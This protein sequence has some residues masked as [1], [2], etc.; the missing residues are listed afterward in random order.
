MEVEQNTEH[1]IPKPES[2]N[3]VL[4]P[5]SREPGRDRV[6]RWGMAVGLLVLSLAVIGAWRTQSK[7][8][9][10]QDSSQ[11]ATR[12]KIARYLRERFSLPGGATITVDPLRPSIYPGFEVTTVTIQEGKNRQSS[13]FYVSTDRKY[14]VEGN[15]FGLDDDPYAEVERQ[16]VTQG[17]PSEGPANAPVTIVEYADLECPHCAE[18]QQFIQKSLLPQYAGRVRVVYKEFPLV[19]IHPWALTAA[20]AEQCGYE[21]SPADFLPYRS[22]IFQNQNAIKPSTA[23]QQLLDYG[24]QAGIDR[25]KLSGCISSRASLPDVRR[26]FLEGEKLSV[27]STPTFFINGKMVTGSLPAQAFDA[28][29]DQALAEAGSGQGKE[30][31]ATVKNY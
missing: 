26:D 23:N 24:A 9:P 14:L 15:I 19:S 18:M 21:I 28:I 25:Q 6:R 10:S 17:A 2:G 16:I 1:Q 7:G 22:L 29:V 4:E 31:K 11:Q 30:Q 20:I 3:R 12:D 13:S 8:T 5:E 27:S